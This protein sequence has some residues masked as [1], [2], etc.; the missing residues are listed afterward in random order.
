MPSQKRGSAPPP[1]PPRPTRA[2]PPPSH[3]SAAS[4]APPPPS[5]RSAASCQS[6]RCWRP[7]GEA[8][9]VFRSASPWQPKVPPPRPGG[10]VC[11]VGSFHASLPG[12][13][14]PPTSWRR[15]VDG[16]LEQAHQAGPGRGCPGHMLR[17]TQEHPQ[18]LRPALTALGRCWWWGGLLGASSRAARP[19]TQKPVFQL[20][21]QDPHRQRLWTPP[22]PG[23]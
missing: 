23:P 22:T 19:S 9:C 12:W 14:P 4:R 6:L 17:S 5:H 1:C 16:Q 21:S 7:P 18:G 10:E 15:K 2:S 8:T 20:Q 13:A 11:L 3:P